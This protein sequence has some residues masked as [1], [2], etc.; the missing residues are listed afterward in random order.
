MTTTVYL[1][2]GDFHSPF[3]YAGRSPI[4]CAFVVTALVAIAVMVARTR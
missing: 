4:G 2:R 1:T 3:G